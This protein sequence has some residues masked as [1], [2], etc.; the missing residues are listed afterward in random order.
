M[1]VCCFKLIAL[2]VLVRSKNITKLIEIKIF[3]TN[4][5]HIFCCFYEF[6]HIENLTSDGKY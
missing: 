1:F 6:K 2:T 4:N 5:I 3:S